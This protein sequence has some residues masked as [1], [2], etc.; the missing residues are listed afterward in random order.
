MR[1]PYREWTQEPVA[2]VAEQLAATNSEQVGHGYLP[3]LAPEVIPHDLGAVRAIEEET[4]RWAWRARA[5]S[6]APAAELVTGD[7]VGA[8]DEVGGPDGLRPEAQVRHGDRT[9]SSSR[10]RSSP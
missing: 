7:E 2:Q 10:T 1:C 4:W 6:C 5:P 3:H 9:T 8:V